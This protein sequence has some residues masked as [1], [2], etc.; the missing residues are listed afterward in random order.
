MT[1]QSDIETNIS[2]VMPVFNGAKTLARSLDSLVGESVEVVLVDQASS[3]G[4]R[5]IAESYSTKLDIRIIDAPD[6]QSWM[7]NTNI[8]MKKAKGELVSMLHQDDLWVAGRAA[9]MTAFVRS[10]PEASLWIHPA[11]F[12]DEADARIGTF[13]PAFGNLQKLIPSAD[14]LRKLM[15]QN[16]ISLPAALFRRE[17]ALAIGGLDEALW[18]T[19]D[20]DF[21]LKLTKRGPVAWMP[22]K[23]AAFRVHAGSLTVSGSKNEVD[24]ASQLSV[25]VHRHI[26]AIA[27]QDQASVRR[28]AETSNKLNV[29]LASGFHNRTVGFGSILVSLFKLGPTRWPAFFRDTQILAR[30]LPRIRL[31][32]QRRKEKQI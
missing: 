2:V 11:W 1:V 32:F 19:A 10:F 23:L 28:L 3:D 5:Q 30:V 4:S 13:G 16:T 29:R 14:A 25:P 26:E 31:I 7:E 6:S 12:I 15:V 17:D 27:P 22:E 20:W 18:Y 21:W 8:G 24:F 9:G